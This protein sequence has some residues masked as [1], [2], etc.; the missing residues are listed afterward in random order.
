MECL[1]TYTTHR[2]WAMPK[3]RWSY[4]QEWNDV[5]FLHYKVNE[6]LL[7]TFVPDQLELDRFNNECWVSIVAFDMEQIHPRV[8]PSVHSL[9]NFKELNLRTYVKS[10]GK[11]GV[12]FLSIEASNLLS[13]ILA[14]TISKL[15]YKFAKIKREFNW[16]ISKN[17]TNKN[18][19]SIY[20]SI[21]NELIKKNKLE[22]WLTERY[23]LFNDYKKNIYRFEVH[24]KSWKLFTVKIN[25]LVVDYPKFNMLF[26]NP[27]QAVH[28]AKGVSVLSWKKSKEEHLKS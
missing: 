16:F 21:D 2:P 25:R 26:L 11:P 18:F 28:F 22:H 27:P 17:K 7:R 13:C 14:K 1:K 24:H 5:V 10:N 12:Y 3:H 8:L 9:S 4:Y 23:A 15:P 19:F 6:K 20:Y